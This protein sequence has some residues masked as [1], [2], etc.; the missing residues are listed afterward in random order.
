MST[1]PGSAA[2]SITP[3]VGDVFVLCWSVGI[4]PNTHIHTHT[5]THT[6]THKTFV[7]E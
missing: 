3:S 7:S 4:S 6:H 1:F 5:H 2:T